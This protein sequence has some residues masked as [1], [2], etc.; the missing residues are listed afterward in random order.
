MLFYKAPKIVA[1]LNLIINNK[2]ITQVDSFNF[3]GLQINNNLTW[4]T[5][6]QN[7]SKKILRVIGILHKLK[8]IFPKNIL[9]SL[10]NTLIL[11]HINYCLLSWGQSNEAILLL[12]KKAQRAIYSTG[13]KAHTEPLFKLSKTLKVNDVYTTKLLLFFHKDDKVQ[14]QQLP[15]YFHSFT[16]SHSE[17]TSR[18]PIRNP[19]FVIPPNKH[20]FIESTV[21][22]QLPTLLNS[23]SSLHSTSDNDR[24]NLLY[25][26]NNIESYECF[27]FKYNVKQLLLAKYEF[28]CH[29][30]D[31]YICEQYNPSNLF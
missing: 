13:Y 1:P 4:K 17:G 21:R 12:Q 8:T 9:L 28:D 24:I 6:V 30:T 19:K 14:N 10:Y 16:P 2:E 25:L 29:I 7:I 3:L 23:I 5:H 26:I 20:S 18:Y 11:P 27:P 15:E 31:C 22:Y